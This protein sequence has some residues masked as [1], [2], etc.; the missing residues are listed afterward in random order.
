MKKLLRDFMISS[1]MCIVTI[2][3]FMLLVQFYLGVELVKICV[4]GKVVASPE[5]SCILWDTKTLYSIEPTTCH[6]GFPYE[7]AGTWTT[8]TIYDPDKLCLVK[9][10]EL[11][12]PGWIDLDI[13]C[14][15][16]KT[17]T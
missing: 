14:K 10:Q 3:G 11:V 6:G 16:E 8:I 2:V 9:K 12:Y 17:D 4:D 15:D 13:G 7:G 1:I 5:L